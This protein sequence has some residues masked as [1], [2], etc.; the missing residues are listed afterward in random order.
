MTAVKQTPSNGGHD[1]ADA[2]DADNEDADED[3]D[4]GADGDA[5]KI[6]GSPIQPTKG[7]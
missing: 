7:E 1:E 5:S 4:D 6:I 3:G 2:D